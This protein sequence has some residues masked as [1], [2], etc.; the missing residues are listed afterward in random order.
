MCILTKPSGPALGPLI[1]YSAS[2]GFVA[3][4][5]AG[6]VSRLTGD[7][8]ATGCASKISALKECEE[9]ACVNCLVT[10]DASLVALNQCTTDADGLACQAYAGPASCSDPMKDAGA[11]AACFIGDTDFDAAYDAVVPMF[12]LKGY[13]GG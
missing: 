12:C 5:T 8:S 2:Q 11:T 4:N 13:D 7:V 10:D 6:C 9:A 1:D 3:V